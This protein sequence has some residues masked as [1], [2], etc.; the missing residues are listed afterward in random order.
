[1]KDVAEKKASQ[2]ILTAGNLKKDTLNLNLKKGPLS[3]LI[4]SKAR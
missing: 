2:E 3:P 4:E 1:M